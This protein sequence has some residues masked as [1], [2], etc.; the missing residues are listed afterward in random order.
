M[1]W[2]FDFNFL[3][4]EF[5]DIYDSIK[6][7]EKE[8]KLNRCSR[9]INIINEIIISIHLNNKLFYNAE[10]SLIENVEYLTKKE[11]I[12]Y[13]FMKY[14]IKSIN[15]IYKEN[16][17]LYDNIY[18]NKSNILYD[19]KFLYEL[20]VFLVTSS[21]E[22]D[23]SLFYNNL[24]DYEKRIFDKYLNYKNELNSMIKDEIEII[25]ET[26]YEENDYE[27]D[28][29]LAEEY[30]LEGE[31]YYL[32]KGVRRDYYKA[33][34]FFKKSADEGSEYAKSYLGLFYEKGYGCVKDIER[35][36]YWYKK[37]ALD[38][39]SFA[40]YSLG[41]MYYLGTDVEKNLDLSF[42]WYKE[43][44]ENGFAP[45][46]YALSYMYKNGHGCEKNVF[47]AYYWLEES[48][49]NNFE[50]AYYILGKAYLEGTSIDV[51]YKKAYLYLAKGMQK[52]DKNCL[53]AV[54]DMYY[55]GI[56]MNKDLKMAFSLYEKSIKQGNTNLYH[57][58]GS[59][60]EKENNID[61]ALESYIMGHN[62]GDIKCTQRLA[63]M[64][65]N[66]EGV[67]RDKNIALSY[68]KLANENEDPYSLYILGMF[69]LDDDRKKGL[70]Y[71]KEAYI[72]GSHKAAEVLS[73]EYLIDLL[74]KKDINEDD[75]FQYIDDGMKNGSVESIYYYGLLYSNG[76][77]VEKN[78]EKA[79][80]YFLDSAEKGSSKAMIKLG[81]WY[82]YG[83]FVKQD[84]NQAIN[85]YKR[86]K[87]IHVSEALLSIIEIYEK[88][89]GTDIDYKK[90]LDEIYI[91][92]KENKI[93]ANIKLIQYHLNGIGVEKSC[94]KANEYL[95]ELKELDENKY[96]DLINKLS[97]E[98]L[99]K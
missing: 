61:L 9:L 35:S 18:I 33:I 87:K 46:Q 37:A 15:E 81:N 74:N 34:E 19:Y 96:L 73:Y 72:R 26:S 60:Y 3:L 20:S 78:L 93:E 58:I 97:K 45:A 43:A 65:Y 95:K 91:L 77:C 16:D 85:W 12:P 57:K 23:Y 40:K 99:L 79:F 89:I 48:A 24:R 84:A 47:K 55:L 22:E 69:Y 71:L 28:S 80:K 42:K 67:K 25:K 14:I 11:V 51:N 86:V 41:Y 64:Y 52:N 76:V 8:E 17:L 59:L 62:S 92:R 83:T 75:L 30:L 50:D 82:K 29:S 70:Q 98:N 54:G 31:L 7:M 5:K 2:N 36:I 38:G 53:E 6:C 27:E 49:D 88:G 10:N 32:G 21:G 90:A 1:E 56:Y 94:D 63:I 44:A 4:V 66:G 39:N 13:E 68:I